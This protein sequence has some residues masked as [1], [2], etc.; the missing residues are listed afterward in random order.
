MNP[1]TAKKPSVNVEKAPWQLAEFPVRKREHISIAA[2][3]MKVS[4]PVLVEM[5]VDEWFKKHKGEITF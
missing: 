5:M 3:I 2:R 1:K 4:I